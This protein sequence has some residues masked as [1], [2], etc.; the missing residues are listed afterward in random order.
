MNN[1]YRI[2]G[3]STSDNMLLDT[4]ADLLGSVEENIP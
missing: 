3:A 1:I 2:E 4:A